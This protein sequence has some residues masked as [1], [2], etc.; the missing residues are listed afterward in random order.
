[1]TMF[2][3]PTAKELSALLSR[4]ALHGAN[5]QSAALAAAAR[6]EAARI[7]VGMSADRRERLAD[8]IY[9]Y[10]SQT[11]L[12]GAI[13]AHWYSVTRFLSDGAEQP[14]P[15]VGAPTVTSQPDPMESRSDDVGAQADSNV[16]LSYP[17][18]SGHGAVPTSFVRTAAFADTTVGLKIFAVLGMPE[19]AVERGETPLNLTHLKVLIYLS[20]MVKS[21]DAVLGANVI[22]NPR[23]VVKALGWSNNNISL[24]RL[25]DALEALAGTTIRIR[26]HGVFDVEEAASLVGRRVTSLTTP[27]GGKRVDWQVQIL[28]T[29]MNAMQRFRTFVDFRTLAV[30]PNGAA[31][32]LYLLLKSEARNETVWPVAR[33]A[34]I[35]G[36]TSRSA[37]HVKAKLTEALEVLVRGKVL[38]SARGKAVHA[39]GKGIAMG[40]DKKGKLVFRSTSRQTLGFSP[41]VKEFSFRTDSRGQERVKIILAD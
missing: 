39:E 2:L 19:V 27:Q 30:L 25:Y 34:E 5:A 3:D 35:A 10:V 24:R 14:A 36:L 33:L 26:D 15:D 9:D 18:F 11:G 12:D 29:L 41:L 28:A 37:T 17:I 8:A 38:K 13:E 16:T 1:M 31:S 21:Y 32:H 23:D 22:F 4:A 7:V 40:A 6:A 20:S